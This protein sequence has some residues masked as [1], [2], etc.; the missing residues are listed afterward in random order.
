[1]RAWEFKHLKKEKGLVQGVFGKEF[2]NVDFKHGE[3][4]E[5]LENRKRICDGL[6]IKVNE[7]V[8][9]NQVHGSEIRVVKKKTTLKKKTILICD[10]L[11]TR[12]KNLFLMIKTADC[13][14]VV[15]YEPK[16]KVVGAVHSGWRGTIE[17]VFLMGLFKMVNEFGCRVEDV[18]VGIGPGIGECCFK[19]KSLVQNK[20]REWE[21]YIKI[22][23][24]WQSVDL[25]EFIKDQL[26][27]AG[28][29]KEKIERIKVCT[30]C[31]GKFFSHY[32]NKKKKIK[33]KNFATVIG[34]K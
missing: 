10:G 25:V 2:G 5:V 1:M 30:A 12:K 24:S 33:D 28:V 11:V 3:R 19:H 16:K 15:F 17:K 6:E 29:K 9:M 20:L 18:L 26:I 4:K 23:G 32:K 8:E 34:M 27:E 14:P 21:K 7:L 31:S 13:Y 22:K